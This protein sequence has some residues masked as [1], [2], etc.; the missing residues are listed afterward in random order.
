MLKHASFKHGWFYHYRFCDDKV[1]SFCNDKLFSLKGFLNEMLTNCP[2]DYFLSGPR[3]SSL[4]FDLDV[5]LKKEDTSN[6]SL[7]TKEAL[8]WKNYKTPHSNVEVFMLNYD[9]NTLA[10]E[11]PIWITSEE[12]EL[13]NHLFPNETIPLSGHI[14][15]LQVIDGK[16][17]ILDFK[18][19]AHLEKY[20][21]TQIYFY[22]LMLS[23]R[24][25]ISLENFM[26]AYFDEK[27]C[28]SFDPNNAKLMV[29][30]TIENS[31]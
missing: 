26:C 7:L 19:K 21:K 17:W 20:A 8:I 16:I 30:L 2:H 29:P 4:K 1:N 27:T 9:K 6:L 15:I 5:N 18:P 31:N 10:V 23:K 22:A 11:V 25:G 14:D 24:T 12:F 3:S 28:Y 13:F